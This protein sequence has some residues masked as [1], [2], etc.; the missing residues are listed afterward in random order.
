MQLSLPLV[1]NQQMLFT[2]F[3]GQDNTQIIQALEVENTTNKVVYICGGAGFGKT[4][5]LQAHCHSRIDVKKK[6]GYVDCST[7]VLN[8]EVMIQLK[9]LD[10]VYLDNIHTLDSLGQYNLYDLYNHT[11]ISPMRLMLSATVV[12]KALELDLIDL[13]TRLMRT[14][15]F[16]LEGLNYA[17]KKTILAQ[18]ITFQGIDISE[19]IY[20]YLLTHYSRNLVKLLDLLS[21]VNQQAITQGKK[22]ITISFVKEILNNSSA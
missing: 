13:K 5:F 4:H 1:L 20:D 6:V 17:Q 12:P 21:A 8:T 15:V 11:Q 7:D 10:W 22:K 14:I 16:N 18:K 2:H 19:D 9:M 3:I